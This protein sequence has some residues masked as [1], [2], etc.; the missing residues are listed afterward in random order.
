MNIGVSYTGSDAKHQHYVNWLQQDPSVNIIT[1]SAETAENKGDIADCDGLILSGG[2]DIHPGYY[3][4][5]NV[6]YPNMPKQLYQKRDAFEIGLFKAAQQRNIPVL[7]VCR[8][9]QLVNCILGGNLQQD[10]AS[11]NS[12]HKAIVTEKQIQ[13][14]KAHGLHI[15]P[16]T[17]LA[18][19]AGTERSVVNSAHHQC[20]DLIAADLI[21]NSLSDD[22]IIEGLEWKVKA[23][24]PFLLCVQ[25]HPERMH[26]F[27]LEESSLAAGIAQPFFEAV[28]KAK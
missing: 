2:V 1:L 15:V 3:N 20:V 9:L 7:G 18:A 6:V 27:Q 17:L 19:I 5:N 4:S 12:L 14:D 23:G 28:K 16:G 22:N 13:F 24:K 26:E 25:W 11:K 8:G 21:V 10:I